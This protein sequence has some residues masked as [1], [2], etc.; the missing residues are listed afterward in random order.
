MTTRPRDIY[1]DETFEGLRRLDLIGSNG[2]KIAQ[3]TIRSEC[4]D[5]RFMQE[6]W[7]LLDRLDTPRGPRLVR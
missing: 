6:L 7:A 4:M 1:E 3:V 2:R 5:Q